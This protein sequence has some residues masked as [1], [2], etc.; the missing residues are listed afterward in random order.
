MSTSIPPLELLPVE[1]KLLI[2]KALAPNLPA[3]RCLAN[4]S[5]PFHALVKTFWETYIFAAFRVEAWQ[6]G[7]LA[8]WTEE[9]DSAFWQGIHAMFLHSLRDSR[10]EMASQY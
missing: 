5:R 7:G 6:W 9:I 3:L 1:I 10:A 2:V 4:A 8:G